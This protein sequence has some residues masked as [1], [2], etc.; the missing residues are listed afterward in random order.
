MKHYSLLTRT[1]FKNLR[2]KTNTGTLGT[3]VSGIMIGYEIAATTGIIPE[4]DS[5]IILRVQPPL[6]E[7][8]IMQIENT[9][10]PL[11]TDINKTNNPLDPLD[12]ENIKNPLDS[13]DNATIEATSTLF[14]KINLSEKKIPQNS[15]KYYQTLFDKWAISLKKNEIFNL[16]NKRHLIK[17]TEDLNINTK[18][19]ID[20]KI[21][22]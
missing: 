17:N 21:R 22:I 10:D 4:I 13:L 5:S 12:N 19:L 16:E 1:L 7:S 8:Y 11:N 15:E 18:E 9:L 14:Q 2:Q 20:E 3:C 6:E